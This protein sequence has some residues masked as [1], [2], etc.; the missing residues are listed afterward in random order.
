[1]TLAHN[2]YYFSAG[3]TLRFDSSRVMALIPYRTPVFVDQRS[4]AEAATDAPDSQIFLDGAV[5]A[6]F[7]D[8]A[9]GISDRCDTERIAGSQRKTNGYSIF[10]VQ[11]GQGQTT[12][13]RTSRN[14][15]VSIV[16]E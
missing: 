10:H 2:G 6:P 5:N 13:P 3:A 9:T 7:S 8:I 4:D 14:T 12:G 11:P 15:R 1:M 16:E